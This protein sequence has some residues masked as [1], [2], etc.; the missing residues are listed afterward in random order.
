MSK[1]RFGDALYIKGRIG[2]QALSKDEYLKE[3]DY[4]LVTGVDITSDNR[5]DFSSCY[6]VSK[7]RY[8]MDDNIQLSEGDIIVTKDGTIGKIG[9]IDKLDKPATLNSH[10][11]LIRNLCPD[12][13][14]TNYLFYILR[15]DYF[16]KFASNNTS[17]S[18]IPAFTQ[19]NISK[20]E[21][22]LP[23]I[24][25]QRR[26]AAVLKSLDTQIIC[27]NNLI[28]SIT[29]FRKL[30][31]DHWF[32]QYDFP[33]KNGKPYKS[34]GGKM[35]YCEELGQFVPSG[36]SVS[37]VLELFNWVGTSQPPKSVFKY[38]ESSG[39][40]R[41]IQN[42]DYDSE[43]H[44]TYIPIARNTKMCD[45][46]DIMI[47]KY[48]DAGR[49]RFGIAGAYNVALSKIE[50]KD[51]KLKEYI[52]AYLSSDGIY[53]YLH[54]SCMASTRAS[55]NEDNFG[56]LYIVVPDSHTLEKFNAFATDSIEY[57]LHLKQENMKLQ[58]M[59]NFLLTTFMNGQVKITD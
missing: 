57:I 41:F 23:E 37:P 2:W 35:E 22:D 30:L 42:R 40:V 25:T 51:E 5:I 4:Y 59:R 13:L 31:Y 34:C 9:I 39:Y 16:Q 29:S 8:E 32:N 49:T 47:D 56:F 11:F 12:I 38:E 54:S 3:G 50:V 20:F 45:E 21:V 6:Y 55:L 24:A 17:G 7:E 14:D 58:K 10:L 15:S 53:D 48:G 19:E 43:D 27:N 28:E 46:L 52:R 33:D 1:I 44:L 18:N 26:I 36:W